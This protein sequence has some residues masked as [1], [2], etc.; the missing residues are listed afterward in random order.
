MIF[1]GVVEHGKQL[2]RTIG[3]PTANVRPEDSDI[4]LPRDGVYAAALW[5]EG[6]ERAYPC[7]LNQGIHPTTPEGKPTIEANIL[8][9]KG[10][11]Y[12]RR[13]KIEYLAFLR[14]EE[15][16]ESL[17][18]LKAQLTRDQKETQR[19]I[20]KNGSSYRWHDELLK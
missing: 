2:G 19:W 6:D 18:A 17:D 14:H 7:M 4:C 9:Y 13:V 20:L 10:D 11:L 1:E 15:C 16:F 5:L 8:N 12:G 3:F